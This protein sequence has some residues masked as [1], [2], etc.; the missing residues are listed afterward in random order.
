M[1]YES[2][3]F[4]LL[5]YFWIFCKLFDWKNKSIRRMHKSDGKSISSLISCTDIN[6]PNRN[7]IRKVYLLRV[8]AIVIPILS[9]IVNFRRIIQ[10]SWLQ[11]YFSFTFHNKSSI[12][13]IYC[14]IWIKCLLAF[15]YLSFR[16]WLSNFAHRKSQT[17]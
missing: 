1:I 14:T 8:L 3:I 17:F 16:K 15:I 12:T 2:N 10:W 11:K 9:K 6:A 5:Y 7:R 4:L 13:Y